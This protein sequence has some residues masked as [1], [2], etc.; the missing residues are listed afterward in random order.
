[1]SKSSW[2]R[3]KNVLCRN[4]SK[5]LLKVHRLWKVTLKNLRNRLLPG[6]LAT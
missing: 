2:L 5:G 3:H 1:M 4:L 6:I